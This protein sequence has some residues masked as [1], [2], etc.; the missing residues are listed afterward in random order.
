VTEEL[1][2]GG[3]DINVTNA[4]REEYVQ[5]YLQHTLVDRVRPSYE[6]MKSSFSSSMHTNLVFFATT[7]C[8]AFKRGFYKVCDCEVLDWFNANELELLICGS[9]TL[10]FQSLQQ[11]GRYD[12]YESSDRIIQEFWEVVHE[13]SLEEQAK[14]L[15]FATGSARS[16]IGGLA[17]LR[18]IVTK[19]TNTEQLPTSHTCFN[20]LILPE[21]AS[22]EVLKEKILIAITYATGFGLL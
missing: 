10:D 20:Q 22:K 12:G 21:Y 2:P 3:S 16:P 14:L 13:L 1:K 4:N 15:G 6:G 11:G 17:E 7:W 8:A 19:S 9:P 18:M 5:L